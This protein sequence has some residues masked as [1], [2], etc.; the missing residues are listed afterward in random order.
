MRLVPQGPGDVRMK[1]EFKLLNEMCMTRFSLKRWFHLE[2]IWHAVC[3]AI[4]HEAQGFW[5]GLQIEFWCV[6]EVLEYVSHCVVCLISHRW[7]FFSP[8]LE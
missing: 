4:K 7:L 6:C 1:G 2:A 8:P 5:T 3:V